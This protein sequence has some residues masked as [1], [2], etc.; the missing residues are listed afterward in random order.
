M[1]VHDGFGQLH[2][3]RAAREDPLDEEVALRDQ[4]AADGAAEQ[5]REQLRTGV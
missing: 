1:G 4:P 3:P 5:A 2:S